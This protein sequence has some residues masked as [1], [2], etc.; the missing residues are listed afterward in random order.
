MNPTRALRS[1]FAV[2]LASFGVVF[3]FQLAQARDGN[4]APA[5]GAQALASFSAYQE[6]GEPSSLARAERLAAAALDAEPQDSQAAEALAR[7]ALSRHAFG[8]GLE[9]A[10]EARALAADRLAPLG[11]EADALIELGR[12]SEA[13]PLV[14][15]RLEARPDLESYARASYAAELRGQTSPAIE[16]MRLA[17]EAA[18]PGSFG[19]A[20]AQVQLA[21]LQIRTGHL[22]DAERV[23]N[24]A[25]AERPDDPELTI[26][27]GRLAMARGDLGE[28]RARY[29]SAIEELPD[30]DHLMELGEIEL[31]LGNTAEASQAVTRSRAAWDDLEDIEDVGLERAVFIADLGV[32]TQK[33]ITRARQAR[34]RRPSVTGD[35]ALA[36]VLARAGHCDEALAVA[37]RSLRL[38]S[39]DPLMLFRAGFAAS[40]A[41][42]AEE[43]MRHLS[44]ALAIAPY[45][46]V[47]WSPVARGLLSADDAPAQIR[48]S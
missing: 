17:A 43:A 12:Y 13:F 29:L 3:V 8:R 45:F 1:A 44:A 39:R 20:W 46:S 16:L 35:S 10:Q 18:P 48:K 23:L 36:W 28:A 25:L 27:L 9:L 38:G 30:A 19:R 31:A 34:G 33:Q 41:G 26:N 47:R 7:A 11:L 4:V 32:P 2:I 6:G 40:C 14:Q 5:S 21:L 37:R 24:Q 22:V 42:H 15:E